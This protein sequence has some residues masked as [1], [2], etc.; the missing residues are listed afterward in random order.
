ML[1]YTL[2]KIFFSMKKKMYSWQNLALILQCSVSFLRCQ[3]LRNLWTTLE[4]KKTNKQ[5]RNRHNPLE[6]CTTQTDICALNSMLVSHIRSAS[7]PEG[8]H[9]DLIL[10]NRL[11]LTGKSDQ[12]YQLS[13]LMVSTHWYAHHMSI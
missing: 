1:L 3:G 5:T 4:N 13:L 12:P 2:L 6:K 11:S 10:A 7:S 9:I 8:M